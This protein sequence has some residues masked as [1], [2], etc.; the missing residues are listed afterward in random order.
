MRYEEAYLHFCEYLDGCA[1]GH[2][3]PIGQWLGSALS[4]P[5]SG[6]KQNTKTHTHFKSIV[7]FMGQLLDSE[8]DI[9]T[10]PYQL[11]DVP[12]IE[13]NLDESPVASDADVLAAIVIRVP[14]AD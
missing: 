3:S 7:H 8:P 10:A 11:W 6:K 2:R 4:R 1:H 5:V 9:H 14:Q 12:D 13:G